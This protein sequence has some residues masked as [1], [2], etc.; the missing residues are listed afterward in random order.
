M[1]IKSL[2]PIVDDSVPF[3]AGKNMSSMKAIDDAYLITGHG[4][5]LGFGKMD[6]LR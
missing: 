2:F 3:V 1:N 6:D 5:I 4:E